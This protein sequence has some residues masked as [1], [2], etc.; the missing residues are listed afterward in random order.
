MIFSLGRGA[1]TRS[2][3]MS[4]LFVGCGGAGIQPPIA[5][6]G[7]P[8]S[9]WTP[10]APTED[11]APLEPGDR[12]ALA[13]AIAEAKRV[14]ALPGFGRRLLGL[15]AAATGI[16]GTKVT[17]L[18]VG[19]ALFD[20]Q[21]PNPVP[22]LYQAGGNSCDANSHETARTGLVWCGATT[23]IQPVVLQRAGQAAG[24]EMAC[25]VNTIVHEWTHTVATDPKSVAQAYIDDN[26]K[27]S[28]APLVSYT[29]GAIAQCAYLEDHYKRPLDDRSFA[30]CVRTIG[31]T[32]FVYDTC[33]SG[34][35]AKSF[36]SFATR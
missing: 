33:E 12:K 10:V 17:G 29:L 11:L 14:V 2:A 1:F 19:R 25:A 34:W 6:S 7:T 13:A 22:V 8:A 20:P 9:P 3:V 30:E 16:G 4:V 32:V 5:F 35:F 36:E 24:E 18:E 15:V 28:G 27:S 31:T 23:C 21:R 26:H